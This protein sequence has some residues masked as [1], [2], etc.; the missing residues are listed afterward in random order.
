M[1]YFYSV[2]YSFPVIMSIFVNNSVEF[3][4]GANASWRTRIIPLFPFPRKASESDVILIFLRFSSKIVL[5][6][7]LEVSLQIIF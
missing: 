7:R 1:Y 5:S 2:E 3:H 4:Y 6:F